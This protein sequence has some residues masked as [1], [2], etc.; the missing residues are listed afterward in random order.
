MQMSFLLIRPGVLCFNS[1][2][3][4]IT[5]SEQR[6]V[7]RVAP[8]TIPTCLQMSGF[9]LFVDVVSLPRPTETSRVGLKRNGS[10]KE[11]VSDS[12]SVV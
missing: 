6:G 4:F 12:S 7:V 10:E 1:L 11:S 2:L 5:R 9:L 8:T 3:V